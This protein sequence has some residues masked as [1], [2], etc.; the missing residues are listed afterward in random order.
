MARMVVVLPTPLGPRKP[1]TCPAGTSKE[2]SSRAVRAPKVRRSPF[3][4]SNP[5]TA[6]G[7]R[8]WALELWTGR[9][10]GLVQN[11]AQC[12]VIGA[13]S[14]LPTSGHTLLTLVPVYPLSIHVCHTRNTP[15]RSHQPK[16]HPAV[17]R[18]PHSHCFALGREAA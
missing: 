13:S 10:V 9:S 5:L 15:F 3:S 12:S 2:R 8:A 6:P 16:T 4:S 7:Y 18:A 11:G 14:R 17:Y 1:T